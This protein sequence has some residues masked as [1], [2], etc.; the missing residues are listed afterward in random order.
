MSRSAVMLKISFRPVNNNLQQWG[1]NRSSLA[2]YKRCTFLYQLTKVTLSN[3]LNLTKVLL[4][5]VMFLRSSVRWFDWFLLCLQ[6]IETTRKFWTMIEFDR[7]IKHVWPNESSITIIALSAACRC[8]IKT[9][10]FDQGQYD[11]NWIV[12]F[13]RQKER[14]R[15][16]IIFGTNKNLHVPQKALRF[17]HLFQSIS[18][19]IPMRFRDLSF[20]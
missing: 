4:S 10:S 12:K 9:D 19:L 13:N 8:S 15:E 16:R 7:L 18:N 5:Q 3:F 6:Q 11:K 17:I 2:T 20:L 1:M 14:E